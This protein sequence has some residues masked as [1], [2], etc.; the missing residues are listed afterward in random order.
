[1]KNIWLGFNFHG[2]FVLKILKIIQ[3]K[4]N[5]SSNKLVWG[6]DWHFGLYFSVYDGNTLLAQ[7]HGKY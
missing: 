5:N 4:W 1:M 7:C 2:M 6:Y 3:I